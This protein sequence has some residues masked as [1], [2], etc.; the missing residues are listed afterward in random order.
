M[1]CTLLGLLLLYVLSIGPV[2]YYLKV[3][4]WPFKSPQWYQAF[5]TPLFWAVHNVPVIET[6]MSKYLDFWIK[7]ED[8]RETRLLKLR[9]AT[10]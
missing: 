4:F 8:E 7:I 1:V 5:Y 9:E 10:P 6:V 3:R 2:S